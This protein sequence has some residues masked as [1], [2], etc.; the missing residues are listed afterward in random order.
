MQTILTKAEFSECLEDE[1]LWEDFD[2]GVAEALKDAKDF[3]ALAAQSSPTV[4][5]L[6]EGYVFAER[7]CV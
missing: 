5:V 6:Q 2:G 3:L 4:V 7:Q 1:V